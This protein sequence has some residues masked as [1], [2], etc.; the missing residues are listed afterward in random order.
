[1]LGTVPTQTAAYK[2]L[3]AQSVA[4]A[5]SEERLSKRLTEVVNWAYR[6]KFERDERSWTTERHLISGVRTTAPDVQKML[7]A[8]SEN[9]PESRALLVAVQDGADAVDACV[10]TVQIER[11]STDAAEI[12]LFSVDPDLQGSGIGS[13]LIAAAERHAADVMGV[14]TAVLYVLTTRSTLLAWYARLGYAETGETVPFP[15]GANVGVP[16]LGVQLEFVRLEK[17]LAVAKAL[18]LPSGPD[19]MVRQAAAAVRRAFADSGVNRQVVQLPLSEAIYGDREEGFVADRAIGWQGGPQETYRFLRPLA[20]TLLKLVDDQAGGVPPRVT[21][22]IL[23]DFDGSSLLTAES[24]TGPL[25]DVQALV[26]PN[27]DRYYLETISKL[28]EQF[29][30]LDGKPPRLLLLVNPAWRDRSSWGFFDGKAAQEQVLDRYETTYA[31]SQFVVRGEKLS[32]LRAWPHRWH[33][34]LTV[35][36]EEATVEESRQVDVRMD[37]AG[38]ARLLGTFASRPEYTQL[39]ELVQASQKEARAARGR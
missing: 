32:L 23:L 25:A 21:E 17:A 20:S 22:Q 18:T 29:S 4:S 3:D 28:E 31:L 13:A 7:Q 10:G 1:M 34:Y 5:T 19:A 39:D 8:A 30:D 36:G 15:T 33:V 37:G 6:G 35:L 14:S 11:T 26:Q 38:Q 24:A 27:T 16:R 9:G 12:G 2:I